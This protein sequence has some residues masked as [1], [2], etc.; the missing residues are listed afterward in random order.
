MAESSG[1]LSQDE[2]NNLLAE[3]GGGGTDEPAAASDTAGSLDPSQVETVRELCNISLGAASSNL[4]VILNTDVNVSTPDINEYESPSA[5]PEPLAGEEKLL[6]TLTF[7]GGVNYT[8]A[9]IMKTADAKRISSMMLGS[10]DTEP[11]PGPL[12]ELQ[13]SAVSEAYSH[14]FNASAISLASVLGQSVSVSAPDLTEFSPDAI[15]GSIASK[16]ANAITIE[17]AMELTSGQK[18]DMVQ[19]MN[20]SEAVTQVE[21]LMAIEANDETLTPGTMED[22][23]TTAD[24]DEVSTPPGGGGAGGGGGGA[25]RS[26]APPP[27]QQVDPVT[28]QPVA[29]AAFD[30]QPDVYGEYNKNLEL[31]LDVSLNL[32]VQLGS[33]ELSIKQILELTRGSVIELDRVAGEPVDLL[34]N[35]KLIAKGEVVVIEDNFGLR[36]TSIVAP[37]DRLRGLTS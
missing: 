20:T 11:E 12:D 18:F 6:V 3:A 26:A 4:A 2:I 34:A 22:T 36:I 19:I 13:T 37:E 15:A 33:T 16:G 14:M 32:T 27:T 1:P 28:V 5:I 30:Q 29:F 10:G 9:F 23:V 21:T 25:P 24:F 31:V 35:G 8:T 17:F 7:S